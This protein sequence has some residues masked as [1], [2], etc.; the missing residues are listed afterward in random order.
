[1]TATHRNLADCTRELAR[2]SGTLL[3]I[4]DDLLLDVED[5]DLIPF[6]HPLRAPAHD[7]THARRPAPP[8]RPAPAPP[9]SGVSRRDLAAVGVGAL[10]LALTLALGRLLTW[11]RP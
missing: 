6:A 3:P 4:D 5:L 7:L 8:L 2:W 9:R 1:M 11:R 10:L